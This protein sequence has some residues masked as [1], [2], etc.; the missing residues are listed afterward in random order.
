MDKVLRALVVVVLA[1]FV[2][3]MLFFRVTEGS[4]EGAGARVDAMLGQAA[5]E[6]PGVAAAVAKEG[7]EIAQGVAEKTDEVITDIADGPDD[8]PDPE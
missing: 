2:A 1:L 7:A 6:A 5:D 3:M 4:F 8:T